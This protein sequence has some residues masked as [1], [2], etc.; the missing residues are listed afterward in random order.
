VWRCATQVPVVGLAWLL[1]HLVLPAPPH[2]PLLLKIDIEGAEME[3]LPPAIGLICQTVDALQIEVHGKFLVHMRA[4]ASADE[5]NRA[6]ARSFRGALGK[7]MRA[8]KE[9]QRNHT[10][11]T[12][13]TAVTLVDEAN[14]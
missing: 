8:I 1:R 10:R 14:S 5:R 3:A 11:G 13:R 12:C 2:G 9:M 4:R 7:L 6:A